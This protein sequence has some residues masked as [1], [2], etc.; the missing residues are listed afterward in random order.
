MEDSCYIGFVRISNVENI[1]NI[2]SEDM[3]Y[4]LVMLLCDLGY[5]GRQP[6]KEI[7]FGEK[8]WM[9]NDDWMRTL[10]EYYKV[11]VREA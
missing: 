10:K 5:L 2:V 1:T 7:V 4:D 8:D 3:G 11:S 6:Y 9:P